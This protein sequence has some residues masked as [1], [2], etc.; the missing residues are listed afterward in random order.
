MNYS[1]FFKGF[2]I[3]AFMLLLGSFQ[4]KTQVQTARHI[5]MVPNSMGFY[6][7]L[8]QGYDPNGT[9]TYPLL[10][11]VHGMGELGSGGSALVNILRAGPPKLINQGK[12]P[13]S[14]TVNGKTHKFIVI[15]P[16]FK[17]WPTRADINNVINYALLN[18]KVN[19]NKIY[20]TGLSM[21]GGVTWEYA[22]HSSSTF[23]KTYGHRL[24]GIVPICGAS[25]PDRSRARVIASLNI[26]VWATHNDG[27]PTAPVYYTNNYVSIINEAPA[28]VPAAKKSI[29]TSTSHDAWT[30]TYDP[31]YRENNM[32]VYEWMLQYERGVNLPAI[33]NDGPVVNAGPDKIFT[34]PTSTT[35]LQ[36]S[37][38]DYDGS[39]TNYVWTKV[40][41]PAQFT[42]S[43]TNTATTSLSNL[44][45][46]TYTFRL[47]ATDNRGA[48]SYDEV[49]VIVNN[50]MPPGAQRIL[51][52]IGSIAQTTSPDQ[53]GNY[54]NNMTNATP[55]IRVSNAITTKNIASGLNLQVINR[56]NG[57]YESGG[58]A[59]SGGI[60]LG[61]S[62]DYP[63]NATTDYAIAHSSVSN[64]QWKITGMDPTKTYTIKFW[65]SGKSDSGP[66]ILQMKRST[67]TVWKEYDGSG[68]T[69]YTQAA[70]FSNVTGV[71]EVTFDIR[72]KAGN[73]FGHI[74]VVDI[75]STPGG[76]TIN[77]PP[78]ANAGSDQTLSL[79]TS[80][81]NLS[82]STSTDLD[83][84]IASYKWS[85]VSGPAEFSFS[86]A[87]IMNTSLSNLVAGNYVFRLTVTD[88]LGATDTDD[89][90]VTVN[91]PG[92]P[93]VSQRVLIDIGPTATTS[94]DASGNY[95]N[96]MTSATSGVKVSNAK[97]TQN[98][99]SGINLEVINK[100]N[101][102]WDVATAGVSTGNTTGQV[103]D[104]PANATTDFV[105]AHSSTT[106][107]EWK[108]SGLDPAKTYKIKF[109]GNR[110]TTGTRII[111]I[112]KSTDTDW[113]EYNAANNKDFNH[114]AIFQSISGVSSVSFNIKVKTGSTF[115]HINV[116]DIESTG[117]TTTTA[118]MSNTASE[119][120]VSPVAVSV[121]PNPVQ[122]K[123]MLQVNN[124]LEGNMKVQIV[125]MNGSV[126]K[127]Y[128][129]VKNQTSTQVY[130]S[131][132]DLVAGTYILRV[133]IG[134]WIETKTIIKQ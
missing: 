122:D 103:G 55:G 20:L 11:F 17:D 21:G 72:V 9:E 110:S 99:A 100:I 16:Q 63:P 108:I 86:N 51:I 84:T 74:S 6:E 85:K 67:E 112:K 3:I 30:K 119:V 83:G 97:T 73:L 37:A 12:F 81:T 70:L 90:S 68:N 109:W 31:N 87:D 43:S 35:Q 13:T 134:D 113:Q 104:Y 27:D 18:Y 102:N 131:A 79:P 89:V 5:S 8:P 49:N 24:A 105:T 125:D 53:F 33:P 69:N 14:F 114:A 94:P 130:L 4:G 88:N 111:Q 126:N 116:V 57:T 46:G 54:W 132:G 36:G 52:D 7:Y 115:S 41:G 127:E 123:L 106:T 61:V 96:T 59:L 121:F 25:F 47:T 56:L 91:D 42:F 32:N 77:Q 34:L 80:T 71:T 58:N 50:V 22:G 39:V 101:G 26:P 98:T 93:T 38:V 44:V 64:G 48:V 124:N 75:M 107:G 65:G 40:G 66:R 82:G 23:P 19:V 92:Q 129:F 45:A 76:G 95:W 62:G 10:L 2:A 128:T 120:E 117:A 29:W 133:Q 15:S 60:S 1:K 118:A 78:S 28:P